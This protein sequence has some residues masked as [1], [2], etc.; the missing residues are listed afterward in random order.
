M[1]KPLFAPT[2]VTYHRELMTKKFLQNPGFLGIKK[3][4]FFPDLIYIKL[5]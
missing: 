5:I 3:T 1:G 2:S 4:Y